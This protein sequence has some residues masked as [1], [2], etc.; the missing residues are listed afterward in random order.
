MEK[1]EETM[2]VRKDRLYVRNGGILC[3]RYKDRKD[4]I[5]KEKSTKQ[6]DRDKAR[7]FK[8]DWDRRN[9][10]GTLPTD[11]AEWTIEQAC[12]LWLS[13]IGQ[14]SNHPR[15]GATKNPTSDN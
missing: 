3:F 11:K 1:E 10:D 7:D 5:W 13:S 4:G 9:E 14:V 6:T 15:P 8:K 2:K 12:T